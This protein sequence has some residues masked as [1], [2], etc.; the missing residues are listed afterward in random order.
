M[1]AAIAAILALIEQLLP[2]VL[3]AGNAALVDTIINALVTMMPFI[4][5]E[6]QTL[7]TPVRNIIAAL[8]DDPTTTAAQLAAL[9]ELDAQADAAFE[10]AAADTDAGK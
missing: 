7:V 6:A 4:I 5:A 9:Q 10:A 3:S 2:A 8:S 1:T